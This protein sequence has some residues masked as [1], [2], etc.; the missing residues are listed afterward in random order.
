LLLQGAGGEGQLG[1][2]TGIDE[3]TPS[4]WI[5]EDVAALSYHGAPQHIDIA[6]LHGAAVTGS[7]LVLGWGSNT[8]GQLGDAVPLRGL[9]PRPVQLN[10]IPQ[11]V[12]RVSCGWHHTLFATACGAL[13]GL[14]SHSHGQLGPELPEGSTSS[15]KAVRVPIP[16]EVDLLACGMRHSLAATRDGKVWTWGA[17]KEGQLGRPGT[18]GNET[19][20]SRSESSPGVAEL[21]GPVH[22]VAAGASFSAVLVDGAVWVFGRGRRGSSWNEAQE[23]TTAEHQRH[24]IQLV[25]EGSSLIALSCGWSHC[26][27]LGE[28]RS[29]YACGRNDFGQLGAA[30][31]PWRAEMLQVEGLSAIQAI[32]C[33][34]EH[35]AALDE[36]G[37]IYS[38]GW[39]DHGQLGN[40]STENSFMPLTVLSAEGQLFKT[41]LYAGGAVTMVLRFDQSEET[42]Q[43]ILGTQQVGE[44]F[45]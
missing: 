33:G 22:A 4:E 19:G 15:L 13:W 23:G 34:A 14:G 9:A 1:N 24:A 27:V 32:A 43:E 45:K 11:S 6:G 35:T 17:A 16:G 36:Q 5:S 20:S 40:G 44:R 29:V 12:L 25:H 38:F 41:H 26:V 31:T 28:N 7:G 39:G 3:H 42:R 30:A 8:H 37:K 18:A 2:G 21:P 10:G